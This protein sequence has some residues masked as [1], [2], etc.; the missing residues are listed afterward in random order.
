MNESDEVKLVTYK[1]WWIVFN[2]NVIEFYIESNS[3]YLGIILRNTFSLNSP[4]HPIPFH[5]W[6]C[7]S[8]SE[9]VLLSKYYIIWIWLWTIYLWCHIN[10]KRQSEPRDGRHRSKDKME[11][12]NNNNNLAHIKSSFRHKQNWLT[13]AKHKHDYISIDSVTSVAYNNRNLMLFI[14]NLKSLKY[15]CDL[16]RYFIMNTNLDKLPAYPMFGLS[17]KEENIPFLVRKWRFPSL[18][19]IIILSKIGINDFSLDGKF[20]IIKILRVLAGLPKTAEGW[21]PKDIQIWR[22]F[23]FICVK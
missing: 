9:H 16:L 15:I 5:W 19:I 23:S 7:F 6:A 10:D 20:V 3:S 17:V 18:Q 14:L 12:L 1:I 11:K 22:T 4:L 13:F 2:V 8:L 21:K